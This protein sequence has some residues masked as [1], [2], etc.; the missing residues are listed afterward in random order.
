M[1]VDASA[2]TCEQQ[3]SSL[4]T[5]NCPYLLPFSNVD[6]CQDLSNYK[7][8]HCS[9]WFCLRHGVEHQKD[10]K[11]KIHNLLAETEVRDYVR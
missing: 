9:S 5:T 4:N 11:E 7:C 1:C 8:S 6:Q 2:R 10:L 3:H